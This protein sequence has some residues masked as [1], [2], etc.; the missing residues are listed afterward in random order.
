[1]HKGD[2][3]PILTNVSPLQ[4]YIMK[5]YLSNC[6]FQ[7]IS[8]SHL[9]QQ[10]QFTFLCPATVSQQCTQPFQRPP[11][12]AQACQGNVFITDTY[13]SFIPRSLEIIFWQIPCTVLSQAVFFIVIIYHPPQASSE[14]E[15][16][17]FSMSSSFSDDEDM[18]WSHSWP[19]TAWH[20]FLKGCC[21]HLYP[22]VHSECAYFML[23]GT[24]LKI[25]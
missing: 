6:Q 21:S 14:S 13:E 9:W 11:Q 4:P 20:C 8:S 2:F 23:T 17:V 7:I 16:G 12:G 15:S 5:L 19:S 18:A 22:S 10:Q 25:T 1:M 3:C 24:V